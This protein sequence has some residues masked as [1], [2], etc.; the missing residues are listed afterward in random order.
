MCNHPLRKQLLLSDRVKWNKLWASMDAIEDTQLAIKTYQELDRFNG[1][2][3]GYLYIYGLLQ[4]LNIQQD[5]INNL[6]SSLFNEIT[7]YK[8]DYPILYEIRE[9]RNKAIGH[10]TKRGN[11]A[12]FHNIDRTSI[13]KEGFTL[14]SYFP[15]TGEKSTFQKIDIVGSIKQQSKLVNEI[16][17]KVMRQLEND[18]EAHRLKFKGQRLRALVKDDM[19]YEFSKL[20]EHVNLDYPLA[21]MN[22]DRIKDVIIAVKSGIIDRYFSLSALQGIEDTLSLIDYIMLRLEKTLIKTKIDDKVE[23]RIF[24]DSLQSHF[25]ELLSMLDEI[26]KV[27]N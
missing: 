22:F 27:F 14:A 21:S 15:K 5:A 11:D 25:E 10:P 20:Y 12:S 19:H 17:E 24:V 13:S 9:N 4:A 8:N 16:L 7:D 6:N 3:G 26:D 1:Y 2:T 18:F 23:L